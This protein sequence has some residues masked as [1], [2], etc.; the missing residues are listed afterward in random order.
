MGPRSALLG[1]GPACERS[2]G[3]LLHWVGETR[4]KGGGEKGSSLWGHETL[5]SVGVPLARAATGAFGGAPHG[6]DA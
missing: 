1:G 2:H 3:G 4:A 5:Y 6:S